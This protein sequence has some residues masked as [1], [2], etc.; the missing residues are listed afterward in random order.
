LYIMMNLAQ[1]ARI[2]INLLVLFE[3]AYQ[4][5][6]LGRAAR[7]LGLTASAISHSLNRLRRVLRDP[8]FLRTPRGVVPTERA[9]DLADAIADI[10]AR[11]NAVL[12]AADPFDPKHSRRRFAIGVP[13]ALS[14]IFLP[15][16][17]T[18]VHE[19]APGIDL[20]VRDVFTTPGPLTVE[21]AWEIARMQLESR[22]FD[23]AVIPAARSAPRFAR[24]RLYHTHFVVAARSGHPFLRKP[25]LDRYCAA[26]HLV[27]SQTA[28][29]RGFIDAALAK[30]QRDRRVS[31]TVPNYM[32]ALALLANTDLLAAVPLNLIQA[33]GKRLGLR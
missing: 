5:R 24:K 14:A 27:I 31:L 12:A 21:R 30:Q 13:D 20:A 6:H 23:V 2:D 9:T 15:A 22:A 28:D 1:L 32:L 17:L 26:E 8:L 18:R 33:H 29:A 7:R 3:A 11:V 4:E 25:T 10:L 16:L 19:R